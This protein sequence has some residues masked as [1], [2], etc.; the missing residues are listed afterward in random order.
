MRQ[1]LEKSQAMFPENPCVW[2]KDLAGYLNS[3]LV[4]PDTDPT[5]SSYAHGACLKCIHRILNM[6]ITEGV[7]KVITSELRLCWMSVVI[8][9]P[10]NLSVR[11]MFLYFV[12][13]L[14]IYKSTNTT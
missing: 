1:Q 4:V 14:H 8:V 6:E 13:L 2:V 7:C 10:L 5:L 3:K 12:D 9:S 11:G